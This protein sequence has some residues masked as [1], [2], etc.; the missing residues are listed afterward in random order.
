MR[1]ART[2]LE[3]RALVVAAGGAFTVWL[4][5]TSVDWLHLIPGVT[6]LA[7]ACAAV[8]VGPWRSGEPASGTPIR[9]AVIVLLTLVIVLGAALLGRSA[10]A[11]KY[12]S[13]AQE[14]LSSS[15][16]D[17]I[18]DANDSLKL[19]DEAVTTYY[20]KA[21]G[22]AR[23]DNY[24]AARA[25]LLEATS[26]E[27]HEFVTWGLLGDLAVRRGDMADARREYRRAS[28]LNPRSP[29][30]RTLA[31]DPSAALTR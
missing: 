21:A 20:V 1:A 26:R 4:V 28:R 3:D 11:E 15:P 19:D 10:L 25:T 7:L 17:A 27:P 2:Q 5:H 31:S 30:L 9:R 6:G 14:A 12:A 16:A 22:Y 24:A 8:L 29:T 13:D 18:R 23:L